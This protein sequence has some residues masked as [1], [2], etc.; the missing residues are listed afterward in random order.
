MGGHKN[1]AEVLS[2]IYDPLY[3][4]ENGGPVSVQVMLLLG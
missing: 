2:E 3:A 4:K 1:N